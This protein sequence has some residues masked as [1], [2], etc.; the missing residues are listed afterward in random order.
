MP[1]T[2]GEKLN[3]KEDKWIFI[4]EM[5][6]ARSE[7]QVVSC[8][9]YLWAI[10]G[11]GTNG[12]LK[13]T[14]FYDVIINKWKKSTPMIE[15]RSGHSAVAF[16]EDIYVIGGLNDVGFLSS[17]EKLDTTSEQWTSISSMRIP[18][19]SFGT[20]INGHKLYCFGGDLVT[21]TSVVYFDLY[22]EVWVEEG[23]MPEDFRS[24]SAFT[25]YNV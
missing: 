1:S 7:F 22:S 4:A 12:V 18:R 3:I 17:T 15:K 24:F 23:R 11:E 10:G 5:N 14:E 21:G 2:C 6:E 16:R 19:H 9:K 13:T 25:L 20:A 8:G